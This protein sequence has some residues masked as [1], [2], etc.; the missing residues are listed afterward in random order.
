MTTD[1]APYLS[2]LNRRVQT[3]RDNFASTVEHF[4]DL[5]DRT[6]ERRDAATSDPGALN[7]MYARQGY[8]YRRRGGKLQLQ[9]AQMAPDVMQLQWQKCYAQYR[10]QG[11]QLA[12]ID[13]SQQNSGGRITSTEAVRVT[14]CAC[15][16]SS[17]SGEAA[18]DKFRFIVTGED[19][20]TVSHTRTSYSYWIC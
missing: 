7:K 14:E 15:K 5:R 8:L 9:F 20:E 17:S 18:G 19:L 13:Y 2:D 12:I 1:F 16:D 11:R 4:A 10:A 3:S 6:L